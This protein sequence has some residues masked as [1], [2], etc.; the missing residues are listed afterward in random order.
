M[1][2]HLDVAGRGVTIPTTHTRV[3]FKLQREHGYQ[4]R[5]HVSMKTINIYWSDKYSFILGE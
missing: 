1:A 3:L 4:R 2:D 5:E